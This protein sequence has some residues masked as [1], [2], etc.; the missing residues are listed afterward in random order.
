MIERYYNLFDPQ[1]HYEQLLFR[2]GDGL[3]S[4]E[5]NEIQ[6]TLMHRIQGVADA[7]LTTGD[8]IAGGELTVNAGCRC[9]QSLSLDYLAKLRFDAQQLATLCALGEY[10]GK[11]QLFVVQSPEVLSDLRQVAPK[12]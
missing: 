8:V 3:Q 6:A 9:M 1:K 11:Q 7:L 2:A 10:R 5:L 4:R 12:R